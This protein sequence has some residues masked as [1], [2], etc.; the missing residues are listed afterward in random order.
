[1]TTYRFHAEVDGIPLEEGLENRFYGNGVDDVL[2]YVSNGHLILAF[3][4]EARDEEA[5]LLS[6]KNDI[7][8][9]GGSVSRI[10][11]DEP[12]TSE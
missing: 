1:M 11:W 2:I 8:Q 9:R 10:I 7:A 4:R 5:A 12:R 3:D 6:A